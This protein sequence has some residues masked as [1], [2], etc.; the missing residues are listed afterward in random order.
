M[1]SVGW[2]GRLAV[3]RSP[4]PLPSP[5]FWLQA[6]LRLT[7]G[8]SVNGHCFAPRLCRPFRGA[9]KGTSLRGGVPGGPA[10]SCAAG[11]ALQQRLRRGGEAPLPPPAGRVRQQAGRP[12]CARQ[13]NLKR[14]FVPPPCPVTRFLHPLTSTHDIKWGP[15]LGDIKGDPGPRRQEKVNFICVHQPIL[16][17]NRAIYYYYLR[18]YY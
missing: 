8:L 10:L 9:G 6:A 13:P 17:T 12:P 11:P 15:Y 16:W 2:G 1:L 7:G 5:T 18:D 4:P 3:S 14:M